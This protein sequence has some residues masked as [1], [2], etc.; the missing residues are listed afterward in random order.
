MA[1]TRPCRHRI[2]AA[3]IVARGPP[4]KSNSVLEECCDRLVFAL[5][6]SSEQGSTT[7]TCAGLRKKI[8]ASNMRFSK[9][10][11]PVPASISCQSSSKSRDE[12]AWPMVFRSMSPSRLNFRNSVHACGYFLGRNL[13]NNEW[14]KIGSMIVNVDSFC[15]F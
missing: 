10:P 15:S 6:I 8:R 12:M 3:V 9:P 14:I 5:C 7:V 2:S 11:S 1:K 13:F 4:I